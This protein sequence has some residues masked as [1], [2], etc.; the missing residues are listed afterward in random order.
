VFLHSRFG[1]RDGV[2]TD[3]WITE[4]NDGRNDHLGWDMQSQIFPGYRYGEL[5]IP[6]LFWSSSSRLIDLIPE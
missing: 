6:S 4:S 2:P 3:F 5:S 1:E